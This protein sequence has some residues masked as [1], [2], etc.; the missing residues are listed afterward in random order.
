MDPNVYPFNREIAELV[1]KIIENDKSFQLKPKS[2]ETK[3]KASF[4]EFYTITQ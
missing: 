2:I 4:Y 1:H 3:W